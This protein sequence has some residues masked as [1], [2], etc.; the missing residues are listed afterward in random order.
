MHVG[1]WGQ[2]S[3]TEMTL[4]LG[5]EEGFRVVVTPK[6]GAVFQCGDET[7]GLETN[8]AWTS[9]QLTGEV[10]GSGHIHSLGANLC[11]SATP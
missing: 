2:H 3:E 10:A 8:T 9:S 7:L 5:T 6:E 4:Y 1:M 11:G